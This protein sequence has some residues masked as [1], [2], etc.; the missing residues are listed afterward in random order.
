[1]PAI[2]RRAVL[3]GLGAALA[4]G[5]G[6]AAPAILS[7]RGDIRSITLVNDRTGDWIDTVYWIEG[8]Y[9][10]EALAAISFL[11]RD[12]REEVSK[13]IARATIDI[14]AE[15]H[16]RLD[17]AEPFE[18]ISGYRT[19]K[20]NAMLRR[21]SRGVAR[22]SYHVKGM[23][24]DIRLR[25]RSVAQI[26]GAAASLE[27]GGVGRYSRAEFVHVDSGPVRDWGR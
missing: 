26:A 17:T 4:L 2:P 8:A 1:M 16:R 27:A 11:M 7:G 15:T 3:T 13:P 25:G 9:V 24:V 22:N 6:P 23:A 20:T 19:P 14:L 21:R 5:A 12:W 18:V 10:G